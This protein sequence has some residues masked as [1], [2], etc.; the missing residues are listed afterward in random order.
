MAQQDE[1]FFCEDCDCALDSNGVESGNCQTADDH[2][3]CHECIETCSIRGGKYAE[4]DI[5]TANCNVEFCDAGSSTN[6][7]CH[8]NKDKCNTCEFCLQNDVCL[9]DH[10]CQC[11][12]CEEQVFTAELMQYIQCMLWRSI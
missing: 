6:S 10:D 4:L 11:D 2:I 7:K 3:L 8:C 1:P 12:L 9:S 5:E